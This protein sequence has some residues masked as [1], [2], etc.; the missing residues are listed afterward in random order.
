MCVRARLCSAD[1]LNVNRR[2]N[3]CWKPCWIKIRITQKPVSLSFLP[4]LLIFLYLLCAQCAC[5][6]P[7][8]GLGRI[9]PGFSVFTPVTS[10][11]AGVC[12]GLWVVP[13][14]YLYSLSVYLQ[15]F[16]FVPICLQ[17][18][19]VLYLALRFSYN[20]KTEANVSSN[21]RSLELRYFEYLA[22]KRKI[23][24]YVLEV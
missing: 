6:M 8:L 12:A 11:L 19:G 3:L 5:L 18:A 22:H 20:S 10:Y 9:T 15:W 4:S 17:E 14:G 24:G 1:V 16:P 2:Q 23:K 7:G 13:L 21:H